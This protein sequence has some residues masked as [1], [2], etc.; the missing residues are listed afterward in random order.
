M[1]IK[2][3]VV[4]GTMAFAAEYDDGWTGKD[5]FRPNASSFPPCDQLDALDPQRTARV[6]GRLLGCPT[7]SITEITPVDPIFGMA[8]GLDEAPGQPRTFAGAVIE[9]RET[10]VVCDATRDPRFRNLLQVVMFP[11]ARFLAGFPLA[12]P[13]GA[14]V[15][16]LTL[17]DYRPREAP[18]AREIDDVEHLARLVALGLAMRRGHSADE[19]LSPRSV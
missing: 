14:L 4:R 12:G 5:D 6:A 1:H 3:G 13:G 7:A 9:A 16:A 8:R 19:R 17:A 18:P 10:I 2:A 11:H 15:G